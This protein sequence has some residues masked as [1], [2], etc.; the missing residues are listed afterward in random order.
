MATGNPFLGYSTGSVGDVTMYRRDGKLVMRARNRNPKNPQTEKQQ[1]QRAIMATVLLAY[2]QGSEIFDHA[3]E[4][5][6]TGSRCQARFMS[7]NLRKLRTALAE[8]LV[9]PDLPLNPNLGKA[10]VVAPGSI[11]TTP[12]EFIISQGTY[13]QNLFTKSADSHDDPIFTMPAPSAGQSVADYANAR[14]LIAGD[15][16]T[17]VLLTPNLD[18]VV[19]IAPGDEVSG[20]ATVYNTRFSFCRLVVREG[21]ETVTDTLVNLGQLFE[22]TKSAEVT[23]DVTSLPLST[24]FG[25]S[26]FSTMP[27]NINMGAI[28]VIRSREDQDV[29][30]S[31]QLWLGSSAG[32]SADYI[33]G[34][35]L[36]ANWILDAWQGTSEKVGKSKLILEGGQV[37]GV[38]T[39]TPNSILDLSEL[40][41]GTSGANTITMRFEPTPDD[42]AAHLKMY[43]AASPYNPCLINIDGSGDIFVEPPAGGSLTSLGTITINGATVTYTGAGE[44]EILKVE[45]L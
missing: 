5:V 23:A 10:R 3:F 38:A 9:N 44:D 28:G 26:T 17:F 31:S 14:S 24:S 12:W 13:S 15:I 45:W 35:G 33:D 42:I 1:Y 34:T 43:C 30:S 19:Y 11:T 22:V 39:S 4:G 21:L 40:P 37:S 32:D 41:W 36:T 16:Y 2:K 7:L 6:Q 25:V 8:D 29:R 20:Y 27:D 18:D